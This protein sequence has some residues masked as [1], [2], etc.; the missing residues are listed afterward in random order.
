M[1][2]KRPFNFQLTSIEIC[3][4]H[5]FVQLY[6]VHC[7][8]TD[9]C[10]VHM[11]RYLKSVSERIWHL[12]LDLNK[13]GTLHYKQTSNDIKRSSAFSVTKIYKNCD[14]Y[15]LVNYVLLFLF[16][17]TKNVSFC[18][19]KYLVGSGPVFQRFDQS[20]P[21]AVKSPDTQHR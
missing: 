12:W 21:D 14:E 17:R 6:S 18:V 9:S 19:I 16:K 2:K 5:Q 1:K 3:V 20:N 8:G 10:M 4:V 13:K 15:L 11:A 7:T